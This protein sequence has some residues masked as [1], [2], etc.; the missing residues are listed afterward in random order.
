VFN[1]NAKPLHFEER[2]DLLPQVKECVKHS[3]AI[4]ALS[5]SRIALVAERPDV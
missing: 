4:V 5:Y 2:I 3:I 1:I